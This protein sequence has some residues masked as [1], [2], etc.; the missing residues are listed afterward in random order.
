[1]E[2]KE[3]KE[4]VKPVLDPAQEA[5]SK[6][7]KVS[8]TADEST[9]LDVHVGN[10]L[11]KIT[12]LLEDIKK[13]KAFSF[14]LTGS[15]G[16]M[17]VA[18]A[19]SAFGIFGGSKAFCDKG[20]QTHMGVLKVLQVREIE[21]SH[22]FLFGAIVDYYRSF[23]KAN[24]NDIHDRVILVNQE[25]SIH[26]PFSKNIA[27]NNFNGQNVF[28]TGHYDSCAKELVVSEEKGMQSAQ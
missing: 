10:P 20:R 2:E 27:F 17:G 13:Q 9:L 18:L 15:L 26:L 3:K 14:T 21:P 8:K 16:V 6:A 28:A 4:E 23:F 7:V 11:K 1:M 22:V 5:I 24:E 12:Q 25:G 19:I